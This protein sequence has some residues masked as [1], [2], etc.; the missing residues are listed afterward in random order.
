MNPL[1]II[2]FAFVAVF[3]FVWA[4]WLRRHRDV[5]DL[6]NPRLAWR[7]ARRMRPREWGR[8][9]G[10]SAVFVAVALI[11][12]PLAAGFMVLVTGAPLTRAEEH[13][14]TVT[15]SASLPLAFI[16]FGTLPIFEEWLFRGILLGRLR[17]RIPALNAL[18][19][20]AV[21]FGLFHLANSGTF[22]WAWVPPAVAGFVFGLAYLK[23]GLKCAILSHSSYNG[24]ALVIAFL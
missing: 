12:I 22:F 20:S 5:L 14:V 3:I 23:G 13:P 2:R 18:I 19:I 10:W 16:L 17:R 9:V 11:V 21:T 15:A 1:E 6:I 4:R 24:I 8:F 7:S